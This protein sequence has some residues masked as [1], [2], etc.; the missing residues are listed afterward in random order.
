M[1]FSIKS[2][3]VRRGRGKYP[4][5]TPRSL[6]PSPPLRREKIKGKK[7]EKEGKRKKRRKKGE[8]KEKREKK[9]EKMERK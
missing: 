2:S 5:P 3:G 1:C 9:G 6:P 4:L 8:K 7:G